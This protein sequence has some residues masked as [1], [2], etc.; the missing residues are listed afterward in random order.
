MSAQE[1]NNHLL[2]VGRVSDTNDRT[3]YFPDP[4][5]YLDNMLRNRI[6]MVSATKVTFGAGNVVRDRQ[7]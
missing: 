2:G 5:L 3:V 1:S 6:R 4:L 7:I